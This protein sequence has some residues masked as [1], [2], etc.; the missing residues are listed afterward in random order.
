M[1]TKCNVEYPGLN[2]GPGKGYLW[3]DW[4]NSPK[5]CKLVNSIVS[6]INFL[7]SVAIWELCKMLT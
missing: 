6:L 1:T 7:V 2:A 5:V 3:V 4:Q